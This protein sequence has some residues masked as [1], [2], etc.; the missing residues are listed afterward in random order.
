MKRAF[1]AFLLMFSVS[2]T[3]FFSTF[4]VQPV[5]GQATI[6]IRANGSVDPSSTPIIQDGNLY[7]LTSDINAEIV[8]ERDNITLDGS[9]HLLQG[10][11]PPSGI[12]I[13]IS[14]RTS[15]TI[16][17]MRIENFSAGIRCLN[18]SSNDVFIG[19]SLM[20]NYNGIIMDCPGVVDFPHSTWAKAHDI[21]IA[22]NTLANNGVGISI[23]YPYQDPTGNNQITGNSVKNNS[24]G[25]IIQYGSNNTVSR[26]TIEA[27]S[28]LGIE[29]GGS[30]DNSISENSIC[31]NDVDIST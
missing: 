15:V 11:N 9:N 26:N 21:T 14:E 27:N 6:Y 20:N 31:D 23:S 29:L 10:N 25:I 2:V 7:T 18:S 12:G 28:H 24:N 16:K 19:N 13:T 4:H 1:L 8:I 22:N 3:L 5:R 17:N 30:A